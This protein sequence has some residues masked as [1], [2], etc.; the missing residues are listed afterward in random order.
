MKEVETLTSR[1]V[2]LAQHCRVKLKTVLILTA[3]IL[4]GISFTLSSCKHCRKEKSISVGRDD[5]KASS[6]GN[7]KTIDGS[8]LPSPLVDP[9]IDSTPNSTTTTL[10]GG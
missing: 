2:S 5:D 8:G 7:N 6:E 4:F 1:S 10:G 3:F 9:T